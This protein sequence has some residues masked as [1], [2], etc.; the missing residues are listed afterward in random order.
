[1]TPKSR[2][3]INNEINSKVS[4]T[5][6]QKISAKSLRDI[7][8]TLNESSMNLV[9]DNLK[10]FANSESNKDQGFGD[11][12]KGIGIIDFGNFFN[13]ANDDGGVFGNGLDWSA[14]GLGIKLDTTQFNF[15]PAQEIEINEAS[16]GTEKLDLGTDESSGQINAR[17]IPLSSSG[18]FGGAANNVQ[19]AL[20]Q[21]QAVNT[22]LP[23]PPQDGDILAN[24]SIIPATDSA[25]NLG[26]E[27]NRFRE[28]FVTN[29][30][31][32][33]SDI[34]HKTDVKTC[35]L[36]LDFV[37]SVDPI[38]YKHAGQ[39]NGRRYGFAAQQINQALTDKEFGGLKKNQIWGLHYEDMIAPL[40]QSIKEQQNIINELRSELDQLKNAST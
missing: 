21:L 24:A 3:E 15:N 34:N 38:S 22:G 11:T 26:S 8:T 31:A 29:G 5:G 40:Y 32:Q 27:T 13:A 7:F 17:S 9:D 30:T 12:G 16:I 18:S 37:L 4:A 35:D 39:E 23:T 25:Y 28:L 10:P 20:E 36:G 2:M 19:E 33:I 6:T 1:M 14:T